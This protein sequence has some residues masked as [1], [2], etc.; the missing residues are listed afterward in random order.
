MFFRGEMRFFS[1]A[2]LTFGSG[3]T[4]FTITF[5][6]TMPN[7]TLISMIGT[8]H[9]VKIIVAKI[10]TPFVYL[11]AKWIEVSKELKKRHR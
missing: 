10:N 3:G 2:V 8:Q 9:L 1:P 7:G 5:Y 6:G 11:G 4:H